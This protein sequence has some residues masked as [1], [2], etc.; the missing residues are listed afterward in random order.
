M[1]R[2]FLQGLVYFKCVFLQVDLDFLLQF[3][4]PNQP[5]RGGF[6]SSV[7]LS[8][9]AKGW[10]R[11]FCSEPRHGVLSDEP[12]GD[13]PGCRSRLSARTGSRRGVRPGRERL[14]LRGGAG[15]GERPWVLASCCQAVLLPRHGSSGP[16]QQP[17]RRRVMEGSARVCAC[18]CKRIV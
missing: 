6:L 17:K 10:Q 7:P 2:C 16:L 13:A 18:A 12:S 8:L 4:T 1:L 14:G 15:T 5:Y 9:L 3:L 11:E